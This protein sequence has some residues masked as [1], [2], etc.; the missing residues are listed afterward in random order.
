MREKIDYSIER[1]KETFEIAY[2][3]A[4]DGVDFSSLS[5]PPTSRFSFVLIGFIY[6][7]MREGEE[8]REENDVL[9]RDSVYTRII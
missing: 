9:F 1:E 5:P 8:E 3:I 6:I 7:W 2:L 4:V